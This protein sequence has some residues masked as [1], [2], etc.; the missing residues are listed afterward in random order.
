MSD[1]IHR[2]RKITNSINLSCIQVELEIIKGHPGRE[3]VYLL[4]FRDLELREKI[5]SKNTFEHH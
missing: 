4:G 5:Q 3:V 1:F 2:E